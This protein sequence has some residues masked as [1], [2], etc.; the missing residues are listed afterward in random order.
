MLELTIAKL[1]ICL[2]LTVGEERPAAG[3]F[4]GFYYSLVEAYTLVWWS[5]TL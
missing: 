4:N 5:Q 2:K 3:L 1:Y